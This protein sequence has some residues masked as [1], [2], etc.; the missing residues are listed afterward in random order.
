L[1]S[2][3]GEAI[4]DKPA[5]YVLNTHPPPPPHD[6]HAGSNAQMLAASVEIIAHKE[7]HRINMIALSDGAP[8]VTSPD[9][10]QGTGR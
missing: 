9:E 2:W 4:S 7:M 5:G 10:M 6:D 8:R 3:E 1:P